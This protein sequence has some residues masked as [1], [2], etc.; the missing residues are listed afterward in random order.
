MIIKVC[1]MTQPANIAEV[2]EAGADWIGFVFYPPS[3]RFMSMIPSQSG[4]L[5]DRARPLCLPDGVKKA[6]VFVDASAQDII[7]R[8]VNFGLD[9]VQLHGDEPPT[10]LRNLRRT[11]EGGIR[12]GVKLVKAIST[13]GDGDMAQCTDY[14]DCA[15]LL[16]FDTRCQG[17]GGSGR[18]FDW[19]ALGAYGGS[20]P[21]M[22]SGGIGPGDEGRIAS[23]THPRLAG[24]DINSRFETAPGVKDAALV[25]KFIARLRKLAEAQTETE[26]KPTGYE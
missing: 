7:T 1:G 15:D 10:M 21:F 22:L 24:V 20:L 23:L 18:Q 2:A 25:G 13:S 14:E 26:T 9:I 3:P 11:L 6:G 8:V 17:A 19:A 16:L 12:P 4:L 5:P